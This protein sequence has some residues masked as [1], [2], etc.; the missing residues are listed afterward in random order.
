MISETDMRLDKFFTE[1]RTLSR[2]ECAAAVR[3]GEIKI[4]DIAAKRPDA[5]VNPDVDRVYYGGGLI[6]YKPYVYV[7][8]NKP[9]GY[10]SATEDAHD[11]TVLDLLPPEITKYDVFPCGRLDK[12]TLGLMLITNDGA[13][14]HELL[15]P[16]KHVEKTYRFELEVPLSP[17]DREK[18]MHGVD[19]GGYVTKRCRLQLD[20]TGTTGE[21]AI[22]EGKYHQIKLM[23]GAVGNKVTYLERIKFGTLTLK[24]IER[25][26]DFRHMTDEEV[27]ELK[28]LTK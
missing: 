23:F 11:V 7:L 22:C 21:I 19:I 4:N 5:P 15:S 12:Y 1:T 27:A 17:S 8:L 3:R 20:G 9:Q 10:V 6:E 16:K 18:I 24:G 25:R 13:L 14:A 2:R 28:G 26:G